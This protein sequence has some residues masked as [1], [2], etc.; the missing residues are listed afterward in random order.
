[1]HWLL[2]SVLSAQFQ[3][4]RHGRPTGDT[5]V[6]PGRLDSCVRSLV[7]QYAE[8]RISAVGSRLAALAMISTRVGG[9]TP[10]CSRWLFE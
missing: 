7:G 4:E 9:S 1:V 2:D 3:T 8:L 5:S 10:S 6:P